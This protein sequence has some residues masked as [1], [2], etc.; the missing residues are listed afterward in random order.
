[1]LCRRLLFKFGDVTTIAL[2]ISGGILDDYM[3]P[4]A[5]INT[6]LLPTKIRERSNMLLFE[7]G[8]QSLEEILNSH[9]QQARFRTTMRVPP[10]D[11]WGTKFIARNSTGVQMVTAY[12]GMPKRSNP[13]SGSMTEQKLLC[14]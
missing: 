10:A 6:N 7:A 8:Q 13:S 14:R 2:G 4:N 1:M 5:Q 9:R 12:A 3:N 11:V